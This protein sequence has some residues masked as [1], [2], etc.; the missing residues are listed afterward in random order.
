MLTERTV[1]RRAKADGWEQ[2]LRSDA[3]II[4]AREG[5]TFDASRGARVCTFFSRFLVHA[6]GEYAGRPFKPLPWQT[7][8]VLMPLYSWVRKDGT[9]R[10]RR[11]LIWMGRKNGK[12]VL[13]SGM[14]L[15]HLM[16]DGEMSNEVYCVASSI[17]QAGNMYQA[18]SELAKMGSIKKHLKF[19]ETTKHI[20]HADSFSKLAVLTPDPDKAL[21]INPGLVLFDELIAQPNRKMWDA[22]RFAPGSRRQPLSIAISTAGW[23]KESIAGEV[24]DHACQVRDGHIVDSSYLPVIFEAD[25][26]DDPGAVETWRKA[27]P[28][29]GTALK[30]EA[31]GE[32]FAEAKTS[33]RKLAGFKMYRCNMWVSTAHAFIDLE[34]WDACS[35][36]LS[37]ET[38]MEWRERVREIMR[39]EQHPC[40]LGLDCG[41]S[42]DL[43]ALVELYRV[44]TDRYVVIPY[45]WIPEQSKRLNERPVLEGLI[46]DGF[47]EEM[48]G[49]WCDFGTIEERILETAGEMNVSELCYDRTFAGPMISRLIGVVECT[50]VSQTAG[51]LNDPCRELERL[52]LAGGLDH[53][54][55]PALRWTAGNLQVNEN[56]G[57]QLRPVKPR[58]AA[59]IDPMTALLNA[60]CRAMTTEADPVFESMEDF[61]F[62]GSKEPANA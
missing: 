42:R 31:V 44:E 23:E 40:W 47:V 54:D 21:G 16:A 48:P 37:G 34:R 6:K 49:D 11:A 52:I 27:N 4:A 17:A 19:N 14:A 13:C 46:A 62:T 18:A 22:L 50:P 59:K 7:D 25:P 53:G 8:R 41:G 36:R 2:W 45:I 32:E 58:T 30:I 26:G 9:R 5:C 1:R 10:F 55:N 28:S 29:L 3:D 61:W 12:T 56:S 38:P 57:G 35:Q 24:Y 20:F 60:L 39:E 43:T 33:P 15:Y 51:T